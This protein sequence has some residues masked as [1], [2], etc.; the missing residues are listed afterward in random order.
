MT[1][2]GIHFIG[3]LANVDSSILDINLKYG[4]KIEKIPLD[5]AI[6][7]LSELE[8]LPSIKVL[9]KILYE[10]SCYDDLSGGNLYIIK[11]FFEIDTKKFRDVYEPIY[12]L[13]WNFVLG[14]LLHIIELMKLFKEGNICL[15]IRYYY[16]YKN[17][18]ILIISKGPY[19]SHLSIKIG[20]RY[21]LD[22]SEKQ[23]LQEFIQNTKLPFQNSTLQ[24][25]FENF[26]LSYKIHD[27]I[28]LSF[29]LL[30]ISLETLFYSGGGNIKTKICKNI[31]TLLGK[32][33]RN[34]EDIYSEIKELYEKR[35]DIVHE[36]K[37][38]VV[39]FEDLYNL[40]HYVREAI[41]EIYKIG[42]SKKELLELLET[43]NYVERPWKK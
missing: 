10:Y 16:K 6:S 14:Y 22:N 37:M 39:T 20:Q 36:G 9:E 42:K 11:N 25:A 32:N 13:D 34:S 43:Y 26:Q 1:K 33:K 38:N 30:I 18:P 15:S 12:L 7:F 5:E 8:D 41:K 23:D 4:F 19:R 2:K 21:S 3:L 24:L 40:R 28:P 31:A 17:T 35:C 29:L 27:Q